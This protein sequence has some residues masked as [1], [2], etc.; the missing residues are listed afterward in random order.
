MQ[1]L[2]NSVNDTSSTDLLV[3]QHML[4]AVFNVPIASKSK[5]GKEEYNTTEILKN[6]L[7]GSSVNFLSVQNELYDLIDHHLEISTNSSEMIGFLK[8]IYN[9]YGLLLDEKA[10][11]LNSFMIS[12]F[13]SHGLLS[14]NDFI[15]HLLL[16]SILKCFESDTSGISKFTV[17]KN[18]CKIIWFI[19]LSPN[20]KSTE[21]YLNYGD[22]ICIVN[23]LKSSQLAPIV[24]V[25]KLFFYMKNKFLDLN[26]E[27]VNLASMIKQLNK[28]SSDLASQKY[29]LN[30][31][32]T[33]KT[34]L[35]SKNLLN[36][37]IIDN[38][39]SIVIDCLRLIFFKHIVS[40]VF[41]NNVDIDSQLKKCIKS[42]INSVSL[43]NYFQSCI[44][45]EYLNNF[46]GVYS[47]N[48]SSVNIIQKT[49]LGIIKKV[50]ETNQLPAIFIG[51]LAGYLSIDINQSTLLK[52]YE[53]VYN[54]DNTN[55]LAS[56]KPNVN[57][58]FCQKY[59]FNQVFNFYKDHFNERFD[60]MLGNKCNESNFASLIL[61]DVILYI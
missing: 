44:F 10:M 34:N 51:A 46:F 4:Q 24:A 60:L 21:Q 32:K 20:I 56:Y 27:A 57:N 54:S 52:H 3:Q 30:L 40:L 26:S 2:I 16:P 15:Y 55:S 41:M 1:N 43:S 13:I 7:L 59:V 36:D 12:L 19:F 11:D 58:H 38:N 37:P 53:N 22:Q 35:F 31:V 9:D 48:V 45:L 39:S 42:V 28:L 5:R 18:F 61:S 47:E 17:A 49:L 14:I 6:I 29:V 50:G 8:E 23:H 25:F 33:S